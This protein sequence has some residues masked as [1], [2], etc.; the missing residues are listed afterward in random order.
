MS[1]PFIFAAMNIEASR[2]ALLAAA[3]QVERCTGHVPRGRGDH[4]VIGAG[5]SGW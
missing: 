2:G 5:R 4:R 1:G 3:M